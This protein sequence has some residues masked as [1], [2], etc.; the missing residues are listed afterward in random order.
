MNTKK[1][2]SV[3]AIAVLSALVTIFTYSY[4]VKPEQKIVEVPQ[5]SIHTAR[6]ASL[7]QGVQVTGPDL[8]EAAEK[9]VHAVVHVKTI[10]TQ[11]PEYSGNPLYEFFF[12]PQSPLPRQQQPVMGSGSGVIITTDGYIV[13]NNHVIDNASDIEVTLNDNR[14]F[15]AVLMG[16]DPTT[17]IALIKIEAEDLP[18]LEY[19]NSDNL[20]IGEWVL[21]VGNPFNLTSTVT[22]GIVSAKSRSINILRREQG[23]MGIESFIQTDAAVNPGNSG[24]AL[25]N[26]EGELIGINTAIASQTGSYT[27]YSFAVPVNIAKKVVADL[28]E[29]GEVQRAML[30]INIENVNSELAEKYDLGTNQGVYVANVMEDSGAEKAGLKKGDVIISVNNE[31]VTRTSELQEKI[32]RYRPGDKVNV[33]AIRDGK[34]KDFYVTLRNIYGSTDVVKKGKKNIKFLGA[35]FEEV[36]PKDKARLRIHNG[37]QV[38]E[39]TNGKFKEAG[40]QKGYIITKANRVPINS[41]DDLRKVVEMVEDGLFLTGIYPT[42]QVAYYAINLQD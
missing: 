17:D 4:F 35:A 24:G 18:F 37:I 25:V 38:T 29:Y 9:S 8:T 7:S 28:M 40:I 10:S 42:G 23:T 2:F 31:D 22:A 19:G 14:T 30:G 26:T 36:S 6:Y 33:V 11:T 21:A 39:V 1:F 3:F 27:G 13:T 41:T 32:S 34:K 20:K 5:Q 12:G 16:T 15:K